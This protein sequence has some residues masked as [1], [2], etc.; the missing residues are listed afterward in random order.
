MKVLYIAGSGRSGSTLLDQVLGQ[1]DGFFSVGEL[2]NIWE[3]G[4]LADRRCGCGLSFSR[5]P[6]WTAVLKRAFGGP[7]GVDP[8]R[9]AAAGRDRTGP[10][11]VWAVLARRARPDDMG[12]DAHR[13]TLRRL[14]AAVQ[15]ETGCRVIVDSSKNP[16]YAAQLAT[17]PGVD[18]YVVHLVRDPRATAYSFQR[19]KQLP[20]FGDERLMRRQ[21][22]LVSARRWALW[23]SVTELLWRRRPGHYMRVRYEDFVR[24]PQPTVQR[25]AAL[26]GEAAAD[27]PFPSGHSVQLQPTHSVSGNPN[28]FSTGNIEIRADEEWM[29]LMPGTDRT[30]VTALTFPLL[31]HYGYPLLPPAGTERARPTAP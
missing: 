2:D 10:R 24:E 6:T 13:E 25:I 4:M 16:L 30:L 14:Y 22:L 15:Q 9:M 11:R 3:R 19:R 26:V 20:D 12:P 23:Q 29:R 7:D 1:L 18:V 8:R 17:L 31:L 27:L 21:P 5:C 28:R